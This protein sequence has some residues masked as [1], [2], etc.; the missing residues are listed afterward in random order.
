MW[1]TRSE[2]AQPWTTRRTT[3]PNRPQNTASGISQGRRPPPEHKQ[4]ASWLFVQ[5]RGLSPC[6]WHRLSEGNMDT[7]MVGEAA[8]GPFPPCGVYRS[9]GHREVFQVCVAS[10]GQVISHLSSHPSTS[11]RM[12]PNVPCST[13][14]TQCFE[15]KKTENYSSP[16][17]GVDGPFLL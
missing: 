17:A 7:P 13:W 16:A 11:A 1:E 5:A 2:R 3:L 4:R 15:K 12:G 6:W 9:P 8:G 14:N 10:G